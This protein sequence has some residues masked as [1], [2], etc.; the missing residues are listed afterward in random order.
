[1]RLIRNQSLFLTLK[2]AQTHTPSSLRGESVD[3]SFNPRATDDHPPG[4]SGRP[5]SPSSQAKSG[6]GQGDGPSAAHAGGG[7]GGAATASGHSTVVSGT[8]SPEG[9]R[10]L[11]TTRRHPKKVPHVVRQLEAWSNQTMPEGSAAA[12]VKERLQKHIDGLREDFNQVMHVSIAR[13]NL[14]SELLG[15][16]RHG[17]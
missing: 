3:F 12:N 2:P 16:V 7:G 13:R 1:M 5:F 6:P 4:P 8:A 14:L 9:Q 15:Q 11:Y 17:F 10:Q